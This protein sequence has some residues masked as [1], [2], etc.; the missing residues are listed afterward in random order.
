MNRLNLISYNLKR[1]CLYCILSLVVQSVYSQCIIKC[2]TNAGVYSNND[3]KTIA[4]DNM[5]SSF[6]S[7]FAS[8]PTGYIVWGEDIANAGNAN[9]LSPVLIN[10]T[11][12]PALTGNIYLVGLGSYSINAVQLIVL[13]STGLFAGG[14]PGA[15]LSTSIKSTNVFAK[16][17]VNGKTDGLPTGIAPDSVKMLFVTDWSIIITTCGGRVFVLSQDVNIRGIGGGGSATAWSQVM[18]SA[19]VP[20]TGIIAARGASGVGFAL[21][22]DSTIWTW[23]DNVVRGNAS[24]ASN[25]SYAT[26]MTLPSG[27]G[28]VKM[29]QATLNNGASTPA[30][31][32][33]LLG[34]D[35]KVY[36][37]GANN[38]GQLG[39][40]TTTNRLVWVNALNTNSS[41]IDDAQ[42][43]S[44]NE[45]D[46][47]HPN[48]GI[49]KSN[50]NMLTC[51]NNGTF[52]IGR[53]VSG[54]TNHL[55]FPAGISS[56]D[57]ILYCEIGGHTS[58]FI[59]F[60]TQRYGYVGHHV[61]GSIGN[62]SSV[63][64]S[65]SSVNFA[66]PPIINICGTICDTP[67][68][69]SKPFFCN[70]TALYFVIKSKSGNKVKYQIN[71]NPVDSIIIGI[72]DSVII[73]VT[74]T[75]TNQTLKILKV[76]NIACN[77]LLNVSNTIKYT[78]QK[79]SNRTICRG[80]SIFFNGS[81]LMSAGIYR[82]TF[83][84]TRG[85]DSFLVLNLTVNDT[86]RKD[87]F[88]TICKN[89]SLV[90]NGNTLKTSGT[91]RDTFINARGCD[92]FLVLNLTVNDTTRKDSFRTICRYQ[93]ITFNGQTINTSGVY[94][95]T[96][97]NARGCDSFLYLILTVNDTSRKDSFRTICKNQSLV[98]NGNTLNTSGTYRDTL[99]NARGCDSF[100]VLHLTV[101]DTT[102]K[103]SFRAICR[104]QPIV[105]NG[106][107]L[108]TSGVYRDTLINAKGCDSFLYL[109][110]TVNDTSRKDSF[111]T[112]CKNQ[113]LVFNG[114]TLNTSG[115]YRDTFINARGC[116]SFLVLNLTII[117]TT[118]Y[119]I[120]K[121][122]CQGESYTFNQMNLFASGY[123]KDTA[124]NKLGCDSFIYLHLIVNPLPIVNA[125][126]DTTRVNCEGDSIRLGTSSNI[127]YTYA[128]T[129]NL[130]LSNPNQGQPWSKT[131]QKTNYILNVIDNNT[132]CKNSDTIEISIIENELKA[133]I[134][135]VDLKCFRDQSGFILINASKGYAKYQY[136][137]SQTSYRDTGMF[138]NLSAGTDQYSIRDSKG[139]IF[140][141]TFTLKEPSKLIMDSIKK[142]NLSCY[143][144][145]DGEI[146]LFVSGGIKP[147]SYDWDQSTL[148]TSKIN[149]LSAGNFNVTISD[150]NK[151]SFDQLIELIEP[152]PI[153][154]KDTFIQ[155]NPC[156]GDSKASIEVIAAGGTSP[157]SYSWNINQTS[158]KI[159]NLKQ[160][161]YKL[162]ITDIKSCKD[163]FKIEIKD[164]FPLLF[165]SIKASE[166]SCE[167]YGTIYLKGKGGKP[168][169][170][171]SIDSG[172]T[173][174][175]KNE[176]RVNEAKLY[177]IQVRDAN[178]CITIDTIKVKG[179]ER[180]EIEVS[181][182]DTL[183][184]IGDPVELSFIYKK[185][186]TNKVNSFVWKPSDGLSCT[187]CSRPIA[188]PYI[189][190]NYYI[191]IRYNDNCYTRDTARI[192]HRLDELFIPNS[193]FPESS[194][195]ENQTFKIYSNHLQK[196]T[197]KIFNRWG[198]KV[199]ESNNAQ[200]IGWDGT[201]KGEPMKY[202]VYI[203]WAEVTYL[204][205]RKVFK[206]GDLTLIR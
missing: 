133:K 191:E 146:Q 205:G 120:T 203:Y 125:G 185:G 37:L 80:Q 82:D 52:M 89:Q 75:A 136:K 73:K 196:A 163:S 32:Y 4:Y 173:F 60:N 110:L 54:G 98:F 90:F 128:W 91:Y 187:D 77:L 17:T 46:P 141:D 2:N 198:E 43:I 62:N 34:T 44:A 194:N 166:M 21:R 103:D 57:T 6:H 93:P 1:L 193:F 18:R 105:F 170:L 164:Y 47:I 149:K 182:K 76:E 85:C 66:I 192:R 178:N 28:G 152:L 186:D 65:I 74:N 81:N 144:S 104:N 112:I 41:V 171:F 201:Y 127:N 36:S 159:V 114:N 176:F 29:I 138:T 42:W 30:V 13:T 157:Y 121:N 101:N 108:N 8:Q 167:D 155:P 19:G 123:F 38:V 84:N 202:D 56:S 67:Q 15:V 49:L 143:K 40:R 118:N 63:N 39:D 31:S 20:L 169:Y 135:L 174:Q 24:A 195:P 130:F 151:C 117:D 181:P 35:K 69:Y 148:D 200:N 190:M 12:Y 139:C 33:Y 79:D 109:I 97:I 206:S 145:G 137:L 115:T 68:I 175:S 23:G 189:S 177:N 9:H 26:Q 197:L 25:S 113:S 99:I 119:F 147:Y 140:S 83:I 55:A 64:N 71:T 158:K 116:D 27:I 179:T 150:W 106:Q 100:L 51:G 124:M 131:N 129:P 132:G 111:R 14:R 48:L 204:D 165:D 45:H 160:G 61:N 183:V 72:S 168:N 134:D 162:T 188:S 59:K 126:T 50:G 92:S 153:R 22:S 96:L 78:T 154:I 156:H 16:L 3:P 58:A 161:I 102:R 172:R 10:S 88:R 70:D 95:D 107:T 180:I 86:S 122:I 11:N 142:K 87:S 184:N 94:R 5:G 199:F 53:S 7:T